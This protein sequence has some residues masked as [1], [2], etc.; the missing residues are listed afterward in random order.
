MQRGDAYMAKGDYSRALF[1]YDQVIRLRPGNGLAFF[2]RGVIH[3]AQGNRARGL[4][5]IAE[6]KRL[7][8]LINEEIRAYGR[9]KLTP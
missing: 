4:A 9:R 2:S 1:D 6:A 7:D 3:L 8:P 5:D